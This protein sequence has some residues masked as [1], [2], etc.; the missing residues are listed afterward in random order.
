[1]G[2]KRG[3]K[4]I[5]ANMIDSEEVRVAIL[6]EKGKLYNFFIERMF[7][8]QRTGEIYKAKVDSV[9]PGMH[10]A[11]LNLGDGRNGFLYLNDVQ[12]MEVKPGMDMIVQVVKNARKGKGARVSPRI[13]LA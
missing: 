4:K 11:F 2:T 13:S 12:N 5:I 8:Q 10:S 3:T 7:E 6:D 9:L 1:M